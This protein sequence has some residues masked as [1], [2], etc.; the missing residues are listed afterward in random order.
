MHNSLVFLYE[1]GLFLQDESIVSIN[2]WDLSSFENY[3]AL[4]RCLNKDLRF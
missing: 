2:M 4:F 1:S 3:A